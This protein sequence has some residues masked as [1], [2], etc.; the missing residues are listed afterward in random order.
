[1][2]ATGVL[3]RFLGIRF[4]T[5][6]PRALSAASRATPTAK[7]TSSFELDVS[8]ALHLSSFIL[9]TYEKPEGQDKKCF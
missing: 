3:P 1:M 2:P 5:L 7:T 9:G 8:G 6:G 4:L